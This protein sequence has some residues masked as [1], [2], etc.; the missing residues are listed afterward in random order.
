MNEWRLTLIPKKPVTA[1]ATAWE[2][3]RYSLP[4][5]LSRLDRVQAP[6]QLSMTRREA[7]GLYADLGRALA[8]SP[9]LPGARK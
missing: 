6:A 3:I 2:E 4:L 8:A 7:E 9:P 1:Y 5:T